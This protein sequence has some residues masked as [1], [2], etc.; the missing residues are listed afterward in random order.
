MEIFITIPLT[1]KF[2][3]RSKPMSGVYLY[4]AHIAILYQ[5]ISLPLIAACR[6]STPGLG[7]RSF[8]IPAERCPEYPSYLGGDCGATPT[9]ACKGVRLRLLSG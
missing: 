3:R 1:G 9:P 7:D 2:P 4:K 6:E 5:T 8:P